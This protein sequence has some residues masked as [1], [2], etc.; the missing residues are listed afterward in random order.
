MRYRA[1]VSCGVDDRHTDKGMDQ[2]TAAWSATSLIDKGGSAASHD[3]L[4]L[5]ILTEWGEAKAVHAAAEGSHVRMH[6]HTLKPGQAEALTGKGRQVKHMGCLQQIHTSGRT[7]KDTWGPHTRTQGHRRVQKGRGG[8]RASG[9]RR[10]RGRGRESQGTT[11]Q[12]SVGQQRHRGYIGCARVSAEHV[13]AM[14][15]LS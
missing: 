4:G 7:C 14:Q 15:S 1:E 8:P 10:G 3:A 12:W 13:N 6:G 5:C 11:R 2:A 9:R